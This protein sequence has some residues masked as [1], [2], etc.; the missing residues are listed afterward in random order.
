MDEA[1]GNI[2]K[3]LTEKDKMKNTVFFFT[4]DNGGLV[5]AG[6]SNTPLRLI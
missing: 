4:S 1:I 5:G 2:V 3:K 6:G